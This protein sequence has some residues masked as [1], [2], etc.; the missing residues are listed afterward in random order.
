LF[1]ET[2]S[3]ERVEDYIR[4]ELDITE[5]EELA[6]SSRL[7]G[8]ALQLFFILLFFVLL[9]FVLLLFVRRSTIDYD[10]DWLLGAIGFDKG[11]GM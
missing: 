9:L 8:D 4:F 11:A 2:T 3:T 6:E 10:V 1:K 7:V 5:L